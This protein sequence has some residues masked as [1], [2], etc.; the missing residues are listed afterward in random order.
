MH[1]REC[2]CVHAHVCKHF[3]NPAPTVLCEMVAK[4]HYIQEI[5]PQVYHLSW[6]EFL[7]PSAKKSA[8]PLQVPTKQGCNI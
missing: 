2:E 1:I 7:Q 3:S 6:P 4:S 8:L 5:L